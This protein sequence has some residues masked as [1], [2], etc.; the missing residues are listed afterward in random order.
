MAT[1]AMSAPDGLVPDHLCRN[2]GWVRPDHLGAVTQREN[3]LRGISIV[4]NN[5]RRNNVCQWT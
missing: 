4:A 3:I 5:A 1:Q 2:A